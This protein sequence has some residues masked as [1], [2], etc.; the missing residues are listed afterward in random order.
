MR[1]TSYGEAA[2]V[3][4][5]RAVARAKAGEPLAPVTVVVPSNHVGVASRRLLASGRLGPGRRGGGRH[6][7]RHVRHPLPPGR[8]ARCVGA[9][10]ARAAVPSP[11]RCW[12]PPC[13]P[14][15]RPTPACSPRCAE[16]PATESALVATYRELRDCS[17]AALD[18]LAR[19]GA[20]GAG[21]RPPPPRR[22]GPAR[23]RLVRRGGPARR[24]HRRRPV[25]RAAAELGA[26]IVHLP[27]RLT[28]HGGR[29]L[30]RARPSAATSSSWPGTSGGRRP[31]TPR[32]D[33]PLARLGVAG[34]PAR[35]R[36][37]CLPLPVSA[38]RTTDRHRVRRRRGGAGGGAGGGRRRAGR[39]ARST[40]SPSSTRAPEPYARLVHEQLEAAGVRTNGARRGPASRPAGR[41]HPARAAGP[42]RR[43]VPPPGRVRVAH[44]RTDPRTTAAGPRPRRGSACPAR[45]VVVRAGPTGTPPAP[46]WPSSSRTAAP[47]SSTADDDEPEWRPRHATA[48]GRP[49]E[50]RTLRAASSSGVIDDLA[51]ADRPPPVA[52]ASGPGLGPPAACTRCSGPRRSP[53]RAGPTRSARRPSGSSGPRPAGR[54]RRRRGPGRARRVHPHARS[55]SSRPTSA[56]SAGSA[57]G[58]LVGSVAMGIGLDLDLVVVLG[59]AEGTFPASVRDDSLLPD[60]ERAATGRR[61]ARC[62]PARSTGSTASCSPRSPA[63]R[64]RCC[65]CP[66]ATCAAAPSACRRAGCSTSPPALARQRGEPLVGPT[67]CSAGSAPWLSH[68]ASFDAGLRH[69]GVPATEQEHRLRA[70]LAAGGCARRPPTMAP[71]PHAAAEVVDRPAQRPL[72]PVRRQPRRPARAVAGRRRHVRH[73]PRA[74][75]R[76]PA[77]LLRAGHPP[78]VEPVENPED[79]LL[80]TPLDKGNL[81]HEALERFIVEVL[82]RPADRRPDARRRRGPPADHAAR[83]TI[84]QRPLRR[85]TRP[86]GLTG[87]ALFWRRDRRRDPRT[88]STASSRGR[89]LLRRA[90]AP[91]PS[92]PSSPSG[93]TRRRRRWPF[94]AR[95]TAA[96]LP[97]RG[98]GRPGRPRRRRHASTC[99]TTRPAA[100]GRYDEA[101][102]RRP[103]PAAA[104]ACS[105]PSTAW[106]P[107]STQAT[108][109]APVEAEYWF[110]S[111]RASSSRIGYEVTDDVLDRVG[112]A[113]GHDRRRHRGRRLRRRTRPPR[114]HVTFVECA[115][116][117]PDDLGTTELRRAVGAQARRPDAGRATPTLAEPLDLDGRCRA[118]R[119]P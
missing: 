34:G 78:G 10:A 90:A 63:P 67:T 46:G 18:A 11:R 53:R 64:A 52:G 71:T 54:A 68:V 13:A 115:Y 12:P 5:H 19:T 69:R 91:S 104:P 37:A 77:R 75:G 6:R 73:P 31:P 87:R 107:A 8:A 22:A 60:H 65:A 2:A 27:Q 66:G 76:V 35:R 119:P 40:A 57:T 96:S 94:A 86:R 16:H 113:L 9:L 17:P 39:H 84:G 101:E 61:A 47:A 118:R 110:V 14:S 38:G 28:R 43:R 42:A 30:R 112:D 15:W 44:R 105:S 59:L 50:R 99:S 106:P 100:S 85:A 3:E 29:L 72:H 80:I 36:A 92:P 62:G 56:G 20:A 58:V 32:C 98:Q 82:A 79:A 55:S 51:R 102:R 97:F 1:W 93:S 89:R 45:P 116:C 70:L 41:P 83:S 74:L 114:A 24:R 108:P 21:G 26:V 33:G 4:L 49:T 88:T 95:P 103:R 48:P 117:D 111:S 23:R 81:V 25:E 109:D 7:R